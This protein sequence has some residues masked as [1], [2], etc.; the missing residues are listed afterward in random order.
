MGL[1]NQAKQPPL[2]THGGAVEQ[3]RAVRHGKADQKQRFTRGRLVKQPFQRLFRPA[4]QRGLQEQIAA[5]V[6][7]QA[8]LGKD[9]HGGVRRRGLYLFKDFLRVVG[10]VRH[11][12]GR[13]GRR[14]PQKTV[15]HAIDSILSLK[16]L[17]L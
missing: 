11:T 15:M 1:G 14:H 13:R 16:I 17:V 12:D 7:G 2:L 9:Q 3:R 8:Q 6:A 10:G 5:G 4:Q